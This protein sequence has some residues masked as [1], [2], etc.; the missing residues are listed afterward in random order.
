MGRGE[1]LAGRGECR[2]ADLAL[3]WVLL[4]LRAQHKDRKC[5]PLL[6]KQIGKDNFVSRRSQGQGSCS[7]ELAQ[8]AL[9]HELL[10][11]IECPAL[12]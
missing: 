2:E 6:P 1:A 10:C 4:A 5:V 8:S 9:M 7:I 12:S 11:S 3:A